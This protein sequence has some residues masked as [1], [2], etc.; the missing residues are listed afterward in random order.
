LAAGTL[1]FVGAMVGSLRDQ[2]TRTVNHL[3]AT[4]RHDPLTGLLNRLGF[5]ETLAAELDRAR[6]YGRPLSVV[7][8]DVDHFKRINDASGHSAG[9][10]VLRRPGAV[11][12]ASDRRSDVAARIG[13]EE[14]AVLVPDTGA[15]D[16]YALADR[17]CRQ[18]RETFA[19]EPHAVTLSLGI[20]TFP[21]H[22][23]ETEDLLLAADDALYAAKRLGRDRAELYEV[24]HVEAPA[25]AG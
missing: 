24:L 15:R 2:V 12:N 8:G 6:R 4:A 16:A 13:G 23:T 14:F 21:E 19:E 1:V 3:A 22:A 25:V 11:L 9:D 10:E 18:I 5:E 17:L 20:A 7:V